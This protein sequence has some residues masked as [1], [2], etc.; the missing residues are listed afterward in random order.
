[1]PRT[2]ADRLAETEY[3]AVCDPLF[4]K[5]TRF[6]RFVDLPHFPSRRDA[7]QLVDVRCDEE[8]VREMLG[9]LSGLY[10]PTGLPFRKLAGHDAETFAHLEPVL[11]ERDWFVE[12]VWMMT[13]QRP[14]ERPLNPDVQIK[15]VDPA[16]KDLERV[17]PPEN[18]DP[19]RRAYYLSQDP[20]LDGE[21]LVAYLEG[22]P[23]GSTGWFVVDGV[24]RYRAVY[25]HPAARGRGVASTMLQYVQNHPVV[26][27]Q[28]AL[29][30][31]VGEGGP[32][33]LY[34]ALGF[35]KHSPFWEALRKLE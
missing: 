6:G 20:R 10:A 18:F 3:A 16:S 33:R 13:H 34:E 7:H 19:E 23:V 26:R 9:E 30:I 11:K 22:R 27:A 31:H 15:V 21:V 5:W 1:M 32:V 12:R 25:V 24:A 2:T 4:T 17:S 29:T 14:P 35:V 28:D 8:E